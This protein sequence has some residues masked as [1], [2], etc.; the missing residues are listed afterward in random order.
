[1]YEQTSV[2]AF[3]C[4]VILLPGFISLEVWPPSITDLNTVNYQLH[5]QETNRPT[6]YVT[7]SAEA[8]IGG[9]LDWLPTDHCWQGNRPV[10]EATLG[11]CQG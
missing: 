4:F 7:G 9:G 3:T 8:V 1:L 6:T 11:V 2:Y 10:Q 5:F